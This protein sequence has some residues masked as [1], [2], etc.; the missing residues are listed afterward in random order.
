MDGCMYGC[1][2]NIVEL[3]FVLAGSGADSELVFKRNRENIHYSILNNFFFFLHSL[4][5]HKK[6]VFENMVEFFKTKCL[7]VG[8]ISF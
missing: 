5:T 4:K 1:M 6:F 7:F 3:G 2:Y 8:T